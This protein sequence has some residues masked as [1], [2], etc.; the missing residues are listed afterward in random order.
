MRVIHVTLVATMTLAMTACASNNDSQTAAEPT[1]VVTGNVSPMPTESDSTE[2]S[3]TEAPN[4]S[5]KFGLASCDWSG[6]YS[7]KGY[8]G[9]VRVTNTGN[10]PIEVKVEFAWLMGDGSKLTTDPKTV[11]VKTGADKLVFFTHQ[12]TLSGPYAVGLFQDHPDYNK[13]KNCKAKATIVSP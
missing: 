5:G 13:S 11:G 2:A 10:V 1:S 7:E 8:V 3:P 6:N 4:P 9:S 12:A